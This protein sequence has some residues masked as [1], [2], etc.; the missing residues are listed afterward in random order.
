MLQKSS[1]QPTKVRLHGIAH[2]GWTLGAAAPAGGDA[3]KSWGLPLNATTIGTV[4][5]L[6]IAAG[7]ALLCRRDIRRAVV[8]FVALGW[9]P[10]V[11]VFE[12]AG[13]RITQSL[14]LVEVLT[15]VMV[16]V[17]WLGRVRAPRS[18]LV[19]SAVNRPLLL[20]IAL[21]LVSLAWNLGGV[22]PNV[23]A[24]HVK[25]MVSIGQVL[26]VAWPVGLY[27]VSANAV[28]DTATM[29]TIVR[30]VV[31]MAIPSISLTLLPVAWRSYVGWSVYFGL[32]ASPLCFAASFET[33]GLFRRLALWALAVSPLLYGLSIGKAFLYVTTAVSLGVVAYIRAQRRLLA[34]LPLILGAYMVMASVTSSFVPW[35]LQD[36]ISVERQQQSWG[37]RAGRVALAADTL[38]I[39]VRHPLFGVGPGNSW[40][41]M[42]R[43]SVIDTPHNQYLNLL[44]E[45]G[46]VGLACFLWFIVGGLRTGIDALRNMRNPFHRTLVTG[47]LGLFC[48]MAVSGLTGDFMFHSI[49]NGGLDLFS[50]F[51]LQWI[52]LGMV[53]AAAEIE[54]R[55]A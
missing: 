44:L 54:R 7:F 3:P 42:H 22:D 38:A 25:I 21:S 30:L 51:Y 1:I 4:V 32:V 52:F 39:W 2:N 16:A 36:L 43:Y 53:V 12:L 11:R 17:W 6:A 48:G 10:F 55:N 29:Q 45:F 15:T 28:R 27:F 19:P 24:Q 8:V 35:P 13:S 40:P 50:V 37:G 20:M 46:I 47:W 18:P 9:V 33:R 23:P 14:L 5:G 41:Y 34:A 49:R 31:V 26:L